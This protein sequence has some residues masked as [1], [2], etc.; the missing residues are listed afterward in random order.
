MTRSKAD[1]LT[2]YLRTHFHRYNMIQSLV[3]NKIHK[4]T[5]SIFLIYQHQ[6]TIFQG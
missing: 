6:A 3:D 2:S 4:S 5:I 1:L